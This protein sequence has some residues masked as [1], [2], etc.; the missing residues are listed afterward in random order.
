MGRDEMR[1][2][3]RRHGRSAVTAQDKQPK[4]NRLERAHA[5]TSQWGAFT[6]SSVRCQHTRVTAG[7]KC[8][9]WPT[10]PPFLQSAVLRVVVAA[11]SSA[12]RPCVFE[13]FTNGERAR[14]LR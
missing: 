4:G 13:V 10:P 7:N 2:E 11:I 3:T 1:R 14:A 12:P 9:P 5:P 6:A 8:R